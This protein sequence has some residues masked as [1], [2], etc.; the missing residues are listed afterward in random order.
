[1][2][3]CNSTLPVGL[4]SKQTNLRIQNHLTPRL[5][6][7]I[8]RLSKYYRSQGFT[9]ILFRYIDL[10]LSLDFSVLHLPF[11]LSRFEGPDRVINFVIAL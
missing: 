2:F 8:P 1:M 11:Q 3:G 6:F 9:S 4:L 10:K 7:W 5:P